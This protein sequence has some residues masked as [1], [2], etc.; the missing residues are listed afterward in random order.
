VAKSIDRSSPG[1]EAIDDLHSFLKKERR[2]LVDEI[3]SQLRHEPE[4]ETRNR[5]KLR[6]NQ[7]AEWEVRIGRF[8]VFFDIDDEHKRVKN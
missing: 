3:E 7:V 8:R 1:P 5:K 6:P 2:H 4:V